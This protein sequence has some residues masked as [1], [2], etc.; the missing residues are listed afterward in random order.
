MSEV[1]AIVSERLGRYGFPDGH[2]FGPDR[3][4]AFVR[5]FEAQ[6]LNRR[7]QTLEP[8]MA[9]DEELRSFHTP[10]YLQFVREASASGTGLLDAGDTP[11]FRGV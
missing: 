5:E 7:V 9:S 6:G 11:A 8:R 4:A 1:A 3:L 10:T 2:P